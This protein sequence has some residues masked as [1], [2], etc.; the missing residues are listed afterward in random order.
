MDTENRMSFHY[1][2]GLAAMRD[3]SGAYHINENRIP[4]YAQRF[5]NTFG[6]YDGIAA[7]VD[8]KGWF[9]IGTNGK[10]LH[11]KRFLWSGNYQNG[12]C[13]VKDASGC[14]HVDKLG[15]PIYHNRFAYA[16]DFRYGI[17][18]VYYQ[19]KAFHITTDGTPLYSGFF[20]YAEP[21]HKGYAVVQDETGFYHID[22]NGEPVHTLRLARAEPFYNEYAF[23]DNTDGRKIRLQTNGNF[24]LIPETLS[25]IITDEVVRCVKQGT[26]VGLVIRH[27]RRHPIT[28]GSPDWGNSV[29][30]TEEGKRE[31]RHFGTLLRE[32]P[33]RVFHSP[34]S[35]CRE[36]AECIIEGAQSRKESISEHPMLGNPGIYFDGSY[37]HEKQM[38]RDYFGFMEK[39]LEQGSASGMRSLSAA[40]Q[41]LITETGLHIKENQVSI[42]VT[43]DL[44]A[45]CLMKFLGVKD[46][47]RSNWCAYL[48]GACFLV[49][50]EHV[51]FRRFLPP[52]LENGS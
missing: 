50:D 2:E 8:E 43:H 38:S 23:C 52:A 18:V 29:Q 27:G 7:V 11:D 42:F 28:E 47:R 37:T 48:E 15:E 1:P 9:H 39:Y 3:G 49:K 4:A 10:P 13:S 21:F 34:I 45:V 12:F 44:H 14:Y 26:H 5:R 33:V 40:S 6:F 35:R 51:C 46:P 41:D 30:L 20:R 19:G 17:A 16:G 32:L 24:T 25:P 36:T 31:A 22:M